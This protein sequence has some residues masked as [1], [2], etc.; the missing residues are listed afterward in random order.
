MKNT[1][2]ACGGQMHKGRLQVGNGDARITITGKASDDFLGV[3]SVTTS[4]VT[5]KVCEKCGR[6]DL[7]AT[8]L[9]D[10]LSLD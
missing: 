8:N 3:A 5:A 9:Q 4:P 7:F 6:I 1:C 10:L 2:A